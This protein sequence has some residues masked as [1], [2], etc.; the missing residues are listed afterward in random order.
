M[1]ETAVVTG[2]ASGVG[3]AI[4]RRFAENGA[5]IVVADIRQ[6]PREGGTPTHELISKE[7]DQNA[8]FVNCDV[9]NLSDLEAAVEATE[10]FNGID[11]MVNNAGIYREE[12]FLEVTEADYE[13]LMSINVKGTFFGSQVAARQMVENDGGSII[14][15]SSVAGIQGSTRSPTY[16]MSKGAVR[17]LTYALAGELGPDV[18]VNAIHPGVIETEM[19]ST[20]VPLTEGVKG[21]KFATQIAGN[22]FGTP[23]DV[24][25][26]CLFLASDLADYVTGTSVVVDGGLV[27]VG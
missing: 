23:E 18:R 17:L 4:S 27:N 24:A 12:Q 7:T 6:K 14:N 19:T 16:S 10:A 9:A 15:L 1:D 20:D 11:I 21:E 13:Q 3:R 25:D 5:D 8:T 22:R 2:S 26:V